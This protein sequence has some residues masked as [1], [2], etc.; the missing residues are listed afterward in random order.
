MS[1]AGSDQLIDLILRLFL[2]HGD[3]VINLV[4]TFAMFRFFTELCGGTPV[5]V[6]RD[7]NF[8]VDISAVKKAITKKT[9]VILL[10]SPNN[11]TGTLTPREDILELLDTGLLVLVDEAYY[12]FVGQTVAPLIGQY[13]N[14][15]V[16]RTFSKWAGLAG[17]RVG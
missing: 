13:Q 10:A 7:K 1:S 15:M 6:P 9:K 17:L 3:E 11:P 14:L 2:E 4:P 16:L 8:S 12:E 5:T